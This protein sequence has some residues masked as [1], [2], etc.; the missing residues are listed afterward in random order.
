MAE[1]FLMEDEISII[2]LDD[3]PRMCGRY[4]DGFRILFEIM[5]NHLLESG[6]LI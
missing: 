2:G 4:D 1:I 5:G 6:I 3:E